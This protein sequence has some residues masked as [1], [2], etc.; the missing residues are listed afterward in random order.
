V[1]P[2]PIGDLPSADEIIDRYHISVGY[3][4][5]DA[6]EYV[7]VQLE[8]VDDTATLWRPHDSRDRFP[9][10]VLR[11][12]FPDRQTDKN[13]R[14]E[15]GYEYVL[16]NSEEGYWFWVASRPMFVSTITVDAAD[17]EPTCRCRF[18]RFLPDSDWAEDRGGRYVV[19]VS[20]WLVRGHG[21]ILAWWPISDRVDS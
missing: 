19:H 6:N 11:A 21:V 17:L 10:V 2:D 9:L 4:D 1:S 3:R 13:R 5:G 20:N 18:R 8:K 15:V 16:A 12:S 7:Q 14:I